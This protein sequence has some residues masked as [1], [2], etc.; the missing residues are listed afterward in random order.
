MALDIAGANTLA[1]LDRAALAA[2]RIGAQVILQGSRAPTG[3]AGG[4]RNADATAPVLGG[5]RPAILVGAE[6]LSLLQAPPDASNESPESDAA[7]GRDGAQRVQQEGREGE[8]PGEEEAGTTSEGEQGGEQGREQGAEET[9]PDGLT[10]AERAEVQQL[11]QRDA[12][13]RRHEQAHQAA[14][15]PYTGAATYQYT[16]GPDSRLYAVSGEVRIDSS[17]VPGDPEAT[18][19]KMRIVRRAALAP[20]EPSPQDL[21]VAAQAQQ[22]LAQA[23]AELR[24][25]RLEERREAAAQAEADRAERAIASDERSGPSAA[26]ADVALAARRAFEQAAAQQSVRASAPIDLTA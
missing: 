22:K 21:R 1:L 11:Q 15:G 14:G 19:A 4:A 8:T 23:Q 10:E 16:R 24:Q 3:G 13:V 20:A 9:G 17:V 25:D 7:R 2:D 12:E 5:P 6:G 26:D 18:I